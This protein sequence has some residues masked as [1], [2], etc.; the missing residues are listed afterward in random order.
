MALKPP[1]THLPIGTA[2]S[3]F[4]E[5][6]NRTVTVGSKFLIVLL[7]LWATVMPEQAGA[8]LKTINATVLANFGAWY[9]Y[10]VA[11][12]VLVC[13]GLAIWPATGAIRLGR[14]GEQPEFSNF[15]WFSMMFGAG[16]GI[17]MLTYSTAE[18]I[19]H[20]ANNPDVILG[21]AAGASAESVRPAY[22]WSFLHWGISAWGC[23][24]VVGLALA[25]FSYSRGLPLTIRSGLTPLFGSALRGPLGHAVDIVAVVATVLGVATTIGLGVSQFASGIYTIMGAGWMMS[26]GKPT[27]AAMLLALVLVMGA[28]TLS[29]LSGVGRGIKWL[30][31]LNMGLTIFLLAFFLV[32]GSTLFALKAYFVGLLDYVIALPSMMLTV[33]RSDGSQ[34]GAALAEWQSSWTVF[35]WAW[36]ISFAP[37][38]GLFLAR[39][40]RGR[41]VREFILGAILVPSL[42][43]FAWFAL[44][45]GTAI[46]L[47]LSGAAQ[48]AI[49]NAGLSSQ[50]FATLG[51]MLPQA[52]HTAMSVIV[53]VL[54][55]TYLVT[56]ADSAILIINTINSGGDESQKG[57]GHILIWG[58]AVTVVIASLLW[59]GGLEAIQTAM[60]IGALPFSAIMALMVL[61]LIKALIRDG[62][63]AREAAHA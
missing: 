49:L 22:K 25:F 37:F 59:A 21:Y 28:S 51:V 7:I 43:C 5:G 41:T 8:V 40:S 34:H 55:L 19:Y 29:A 45:G 31:N 42:V 10:V 57:G 39:V 4:Y 2:S 12:F 9:V 56:S 24:A 16:I 54:L 30:S 33:W 48:G 26:D 14:P 61:A 18:P 17:G 38:T 50:L 52:L 35:Y 20:F 62:I 63:R 13:F 58:A 15:S 36:W 47:E 3:G 32:F 44:V 60:I 23:Y 27:I 53:V 11:A 46:D 1:L 6:F